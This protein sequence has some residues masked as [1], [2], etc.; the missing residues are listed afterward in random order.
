MAYYEKGMGDV[1]CVFSCGWAVPL[2]FSDMLELAELLS[3]AYRCIIFDRFGY[4]FSD[5]GHGKRA[6]STITEET[7]LLCDALGITGSVIYIGHS[8]STFHA[9]DF[10]KKYPEMIMGLVLID[11]Y[12]FSSALSRSA[13]AW[14]WLIAYYCVFMR[15]S[16]LISKIKDKRLKKLLLG[17]RE[18][19]EDILEDVL[20]ITR[21]RLYNKTVR[22]ELSA[23]I[24][25]LKYLNIGLDKLDMPITAVCRN[26]SYRNN[27]KMSRHISAHRVIN[28]GKATHFIHYEYPEIV[29]N[30]V[31]KITKRD[32]YSS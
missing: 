19:P 18:V 6:F 14:N 29:S 7:K 13:F 23:A 26:A 31:D 30:E 27:K 21:K 5:D 10:A 15:K 16:G 11:S 25:D 9:L 4:G 2:P 20:A 28:V 22:D 3:G 8:L 1:T 17:H 32:C 24:K 12:N